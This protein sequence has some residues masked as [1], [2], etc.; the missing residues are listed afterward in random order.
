MTSYKSHAYGHMHAEW[1]KKR[2]SVPRDT[3]MHE[4]SLMPVP[5]IN[6]FVSYNIHGGIAG[7]QHTHAI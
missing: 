7:K 2:L 3:Y 5:V 6:L 4:V 1:Q